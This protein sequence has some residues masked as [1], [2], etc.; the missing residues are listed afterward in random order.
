MP[1]LSQSLS[2]NERAKAFDYFNPPE[3]YIDSPYPWFKLLRD[4]DPLHRNSDGSVLL[5]RHADVST[6]WRDLS[7]VVDKKE[8]FLKRWGEGPLLDHYT[9]GMLYRDPPDHDRLRRFVNPIFYQSNIERQI[10][11]IQETVEKLLDEAEEKKQIDF[12][13]DFAARI[14]IAVICKLL[15]VPQ[16]DA[17]L[18]QDLGRRILVPLNARVTQEIVASGNEAVRTFNTYMQDFLNDA[19]KRRDLDPTKEVVSALIVAERNSE[20]ITPDEMVHMCIMMLNG[21]HETT[22]NLIATSM[23]SLLDQPDQ[24]GLLRDNPDVMS[25]GVEELIRFVSP[26]QFQGRRTARPIKIPSGEIEPGVEVIVC[27]ASANRDERVFENPE[28]IDLR[29]K[30]PNKH[31]AFGAG[32]HVCIGQPLARLELKYALPAFVRR[33]KLIERNGEARFNPNPRFRGLFGLPLRLQ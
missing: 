14:P 21:G 30:S 32:I 26:L 16:S 33:F 19:R 22:T 29:R 7:G 1:A 31:L 3:G 27:Q 25:T 5:T 20:Q 6:V 11:F 8:A 4:H 28:E 9:T 12:L 17:D 10:E 23:H 24:L 2:D 15:C 13:H 18:I